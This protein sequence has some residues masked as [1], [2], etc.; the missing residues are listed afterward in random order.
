MREKSV[1][2]SA[3]CFRWNVFGFRSPFRP[4]LSDPERHRGSFEDG[5]PAGP[6]E[7]RLRGE[8]CPGLLERDASER[9]A[10]EFE[11]G[12]VQ[13]LPGVPSAPDGRT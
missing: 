8:R 6:R 11:C 10:Q 7:H 4:L 12:G 3:E 2:F 1:R 13:L 5:P 9:A